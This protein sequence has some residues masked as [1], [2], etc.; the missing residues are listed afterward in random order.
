MLIFPSLTFSPCTAIC[1]PTATE[2][3]TKLEVVIM[4]DINHYSSH[5][6]SS[7]VGSVVM[8]MPGWSNCMFD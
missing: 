2:L 3:S 5:A 8:N 1:G 7:A 4:V 6:S